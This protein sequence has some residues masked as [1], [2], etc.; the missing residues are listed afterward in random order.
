MDVKSWPHRPSPAAGAGVLAGWG[1]C[2]ERGRRRQPST[3][4]GSGAPVH[5][6]WRSPVRPRLRRS[7]HSGTLCPR[8]GDTRR[9]AVLRVVEGELALPLVGELRQAARGLSSARLRRRC[10]RPYVSADREPRGRRKPPTRTSDT[11]GRV[12][13][14]PRRRTSRTSSTPSLLSTYL[15]RL[16]HPAGRPALIFFQVVKS[17]GLRVGES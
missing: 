15:H 6:S 7:F 4:R 14:S 1:P 11:P 5:A 16:R 12:V 10:R 8:S 9:L 17:C 13:G 2:S 3:G